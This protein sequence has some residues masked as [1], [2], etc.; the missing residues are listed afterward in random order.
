ML[1]RVKAAVRTNFTE[2]NNQTPLNQ[3]SAPQNHPIQ[4]S[5]LRR[6]YSSQPIQYS[7]LQRTSILQP[8]QDSVL[9]TSTSQPTQDYLE[10]RT[11][12][13]PISEY[14]EYS[15]T[16]QASQTLSAGT[17]PNPFSNLNLTNPNP[18]QYF[19][20]NQSLQR[21]PELNVESLDEEDSDS[22]ACNRTVVPVPIP[23]P[24]PGPSRLQYTTL[25]NPDLRI[26]NCYIKQPL[27]NYKPV[28]RIPFELF[29][30]ETQHRPQVITRVFLGPPHITTRSSTPTT[31]LVIAS[32]DNCR[33]CTTLFTN[34]TLSQTQQSHTTLSQAQQCD[35]TASQEQQSNTP[36]SKTRQSDSTA[37]QEQQTKEQQSICTSE[38]TPEPTPN[39]ITNDSSSQHTR[40]RPLPP[41]PTPILP[42][43]DIP[44]FT[45]TPSDHSS[46]LFEPETAFVHS[47]TPNS[48]TLIS[49]NTVYLPSSRY[50]IFPQP[51][52]FPNPSFLPPYN[53][54]PP[55]NPP[56]QPAD[57]IRGSLNPFTTQ[58][59]KSKITHP[60]TTFSTISSN[61]PPYSANPVPNPQQVNIA[62]A[63]A[64]S[65]N[66]VQ[67]IAPTVL[68]TFDPEKDD[69]SDFLR[70]FDTT[71]Q[72]WYDNQVM[73]GDFRSINDLRQHLHRLEDARHNFGEDL[74]YFEM[75]NQ[76]STKT[77]A[78]E[79]RSYPTT[80]A[81][82]INFLTATSTI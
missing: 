39:L 73:A 30:V 19:V 70:S 59:C 64:L 27:S 17:S 50:T 7:I 61:P 4:D 1:N 66:A 45:F 53:Q 54:F 8:I 11:E 35:S 77:S 72:G 2:D 32:S 65:Q 22:E 28:T 5:V 82:P 31:Q 76:S 58:S 16:R 68:Q 6:T 69:K 56:T 34:S 52:F 23:K 62:F 60:D 47:K 33:T 51:R 75:L 67:F 38:T 79:K 25:V 41:T 57:S 78:I 74:P 71:S 46:P 20:K 48:V 63:P 42:Q 24:R 37:S 49:S 15:N 81:T 14:S 18:Y 36:L 43:F 55:I 44:D 29:F 13:A 3:N 9:R 80:T 40:N 26:I 21:I 12:I 10:Y